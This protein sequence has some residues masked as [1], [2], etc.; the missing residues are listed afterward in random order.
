MPIF[1]RLGRSNKIKHWPTFFC[2]PCAIAVDQIMFSNHSAYILS[3]LP[4]TQTHR[5]IIK[6]NYFWTQFQWCLNSRRYIKI[7]FE[8]DCQLRNFHSNKSCAS[9]IHPKEK[10][11]E[12]REEEKSSKNK[13]R[14]KGVKSVKSWQ[15]SRC[16][17]STSRKQNNKNK[18]T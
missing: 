8:G 6:K 15:M 3:A 14:V 7:Y 13:I 16:E 12:R 10:L 11:R 18:I 2:K 4:I 5:R 9:S 17:R 1:L